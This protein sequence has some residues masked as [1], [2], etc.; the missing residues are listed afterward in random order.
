LHRIAERCEDKPA[1]RFSLFG[2]SIQVLP[3]L[4][5]EG[6]TLTYIHCRMGIARAVPLYGLALFFSRGPQPL[7]TPN[8]PPVV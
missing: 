5:T 6:A 8:I 4:L 3:E 2:N 1:D 7:M